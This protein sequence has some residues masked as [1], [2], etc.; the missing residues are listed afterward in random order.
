MAVQQFHYLNE[1]RHP[2]LMRR[3]KNGIATV[4]E[5]L[6]WHYLRTTTNAV[7]CM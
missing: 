5:G 4:R 3:Q 7:E 6:E 2:Q 1:P